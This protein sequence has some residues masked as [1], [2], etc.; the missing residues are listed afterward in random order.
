LEFWAICKGV[1]GKELATDKHR[2]APINAM[3][4]YLFQS[5]IIGVHRWLNLS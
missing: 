5:V 1:L 3:I 4:L 2:W